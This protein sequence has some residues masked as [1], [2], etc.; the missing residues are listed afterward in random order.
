VPT[1]RAFGE[2]LVRRLGARLIRI[3]VR[4][5]QVPAGEIAIAEGALPAL[6]AID[7]HIASLD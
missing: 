2:S 7:A 3:N 4:E 1:V 6:T 5:P